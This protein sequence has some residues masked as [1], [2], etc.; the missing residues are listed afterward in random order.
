MRLSVDNAF[1]HGIIDEDLAKQLKK[2]ENLSLCQFFHA[3]TKDTVS[4]PEAIKLG[5]V[6][7]DL[8]REIQEIQALTGSFVDLISGQRLTLAE[9]EKEGLLT[10]NKAILSS[11]MMHGI[12]D[13]ESYRIVPYSELVKKCKID[14]ESGQRYLE[15]IPF[16]DIKDETSGKVLTLSQAAQLRKVDFISTLK[17]L[18]AQANT[19][20]IIDTATG[21]R[22]TLAS[23]LEQKLVDE[24]MV[25]IIATHQVLN[26]G[27]VDIFN[28]QRVTLKEAVEKGFISPELATMIQVDTLE[29]CDHGA[30]IEKQ[31][32]IE[33]CE[34]EKEF[35]RK[36]MLVACNRT[37]GMSYG[38]G[39]SEKLFEIGSQS[40]QG[41][42]K[43]RVSDG[44]QAK[45]SRE[46]SLKELEYKDQDKRRTSPDAEESV[47]I[48]I[49]G[50]HKDT[51]LG[52]GSVILSH[53][54]SHDFKLK[55]VTR[56]DL[57]KNTNEEQENIEAQMEI[58]SHM[59]QSISGPDP[60]EIRESQGRIISEVQESD[61]ETS[62]KLLSEQVM[63]KPMNTR[64]K[65]K[66]EKREEIIEESVKT[67]K[68]VLS[69]EKLNQET[70]IG[71]DQ[72]S[73]V[74]SPPVEISINEKGEEAGKEL[75]FICKAEN[76]SPVIPRGIS[77]NQDV[78]TFFKPN[79]VHE[80]EVKNLSLS[81]LKPEEN[82]SQIT[83]GAQS[84]PFSST[85]PGPEGLY[86]QESVGKAQVAGRS[87]ISESNKPFQGTI[88]PETNS[89]QDSSLTFKT[90]ET[91]DLICS[92]NEYK[93]RSYQEIPFDSTRILRLEETT[94]STVDPKEVSYLE[95]S[96]RKD[97]HHQDS[98]S[99]SEICG[100]LTSKITTQEMTGETSL[101]M[102]NPI[103]TDVEAA[104]S[105]GMVTQDVPRVLA[106]LL[107]EKL[108][109]DGSQKERAEQ[110]DATISPPIP[111]TS[112][113]K[114][115]PLIYPTMKTDEKT[116]QEK[117]RESPGGEQIPFMTTAGGRGN[118]GVNPEPSRTTKVS[119][120]VVCLYVYFRCN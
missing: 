101:E 85:A 105:K 7:P 80:G 39:A 89:C 45:K 117:L 62:G 88:R 38:K 64:E 70:T 55:E 84:E 110:Q 90:K 16:S 22:L 31:D 87:Q 104:S 14:I 61:Y 53:P 26:G 33:V 115:M 43:T 18:E 2:V 86:Y 79:Q 72:G 23:A 82:L 19:G 74:E 3:E 20:G 25:R 75:G 94:V 83:G 65:T 4:L 49:P 5:L 27:I 107:P 100:I 28:D 63:Q 40:A 119:F 35:L 57:E 93:E 77:V 1:E 102:S 120:P 69:E 112:E 99:D 71:A 32:G 116:P 41:K 91:K 106:S 11:G 30:Q 111:E 81:T 10:T 56:D 54:E 108:F 13:P 44:G 66:R 95:F 73:N 36:E 24:N 52:Q 114:P 29:S 109:K 9:A 78:L 47:S 46:I 60:K 50:D 68:P 113:E 67:R 17:V 34:I 59:K 98:R 15:V 21:K 76:S 97:F 51:S 118:E 103:V 42:V 12:I 92:S 37:A 6:T 58:T 48:I 8:K 96:D